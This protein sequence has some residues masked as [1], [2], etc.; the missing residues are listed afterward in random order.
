MLTE[1]P[2]SAQDSVRCS[3]RGVNYRLRRTCPEDKDTVLSERRKGAKEAFRVEGKA[4]GRATKRQMHT[5]ETLRAP[6]Q[7]FSRKANPE[8]RM[9][10]GKSQGS[11]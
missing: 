3:Y 8:K 11:H 6:G 2:N 10:R 9:K 7:K 4:P 5:G 1:K